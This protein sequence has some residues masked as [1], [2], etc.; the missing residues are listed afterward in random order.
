[1]APYR[2][3]VLRMLVPL[4]L[5]LLA[6]CAT[7]PQAPSTAQLAAV[8]RV[9]AQ[10][11]QGDYAAAAAEWLRLAREYKA[12]RDGYLL[13]AAENFRQLGN[14]TRA[15][16]V[17][18]RIEP[19]GLSFAE[20]I[21][22]DLLNAGAALAAGDVE[23]A[24][25]LTSNAGQLP[26]KWRLRGQELRARALAAAGQPLEA[27]RV[28]MDMNALLAGFDR[29]QNEKQLLQLLQGMDPAELQA[30]ASSLG[31]QDP[32]RVWVSEALEAS[33]KSLPTTMP[34]PQYPVGTLLPTSGHTKV[35]AEGYVPLQ[36]VALILP[37]S[38]ALQAAGKA[39]HDGFMQA[40][41]RDASH[42]ANMQLDVL[43][44]GGSPM[45][46]LQ[47]YREALAAGVELVVGPLSSAGVA[48]VFRR[49]AL[50][51]PVLALNHPDQGM[52]PAGSSEFAMPPE[53]EGARVAMRMRMRGLNQAV[54]FE[55]DTD[56]AQRA[57]GAFQAQFEGNGGTVTG[58]ATLPRTQ[59]N[60]ASAIQALLAN[61]GP[62]T[63]VFIAMGP[64]QG[65]L[66]VPQLRIARVTQPL[67][68]TSHIYA[69]ETNVGLDRDLDGV[70]FCDV[71]WLFGAQSGIVDR[72]SL[73]EENPSIRGP[74]A[75][76][77]AFGMDA[78]ALMPYLDWLRSHPGSYLPG[79][80]GQLTMDSFGRIRRTPIWATFING[81]ATPVTGAL[82][83]DAGMPL[84]QNP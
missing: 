61:A 65:R 6:S 70:V 40:W 67:F 66:L 45:G 57:A 63:G 5:V 42:T 9:E 13:N 55:A 1:M 50:P 7:V 16:G 77:F 69:G 34:Q 8:Q 81:V 51:V 71:P 52:P 12:W 76:L 41:T 31:A 17:L 30:R 48:A 14:W 37:M 26:Q 53:A 46:A 80:T 20:G 59:V 79:A 82:V 4:L 28:R 24:L 10:Q 78:F 44:T 18:Q 43:D 32:L 36:K 3:V 73:D 29:G 74:A 2:S 56:W 72:A 64:R 35:T 22:F 23:R 54:I 21:Q 15:S 39:V 19:R 49:D 68:A 75:R 27:A 25:T 38:G 62:A 11:Q 84:P 47:A 58:T 33:G 83:G 60:Y